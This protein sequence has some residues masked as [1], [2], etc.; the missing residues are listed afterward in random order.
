MS[1]DK[2]EQIRSKICRHIRHT[3]AYCENVTREE[4]HRNLMLQEACIFNV[5]QVGE[6]AAKAIEYGIDEEQPEIEWK[7]MRGM[8][9]RIVHD[10]EGV[11]LEIIW[12]T[13]QNDLPELLRKMERDEGHR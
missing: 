4:F 13:I 12:D 3:L 6:L 5:L 10:Y 7:Q 11:R 1:S 9:N 2:Y 8:R